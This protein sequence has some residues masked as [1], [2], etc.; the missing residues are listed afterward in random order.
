MPA[1]SPL[2]W[3]RRFE[4]STADIS[5]AHRYGIVPS[6]AKART[7]MVVRLLE[8][9]ELDCTRQRPTATNRLRPGIVRACID[10]HH[11][12]VSLF[13][14]IEVAMLALVRSTAIEYTAPNIPL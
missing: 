6:A 14:N 13:S 5:R 11:A 12:C 8:S 9:S 10:A 7:A 4:G 3:H 2:L 1:P